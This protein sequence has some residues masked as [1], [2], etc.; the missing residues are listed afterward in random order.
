MRH[1]VTRL[2]LDQQ[3]ARDQRTAPRPL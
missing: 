1:T 3:S 2:E